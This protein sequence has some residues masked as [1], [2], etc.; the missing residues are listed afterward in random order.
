MGPSTGHQVPLPAE[1]TGRASPIGYAPSRSTPLRST[2]SQALT[3][4]Q[5]MIKALL[6]HLGHK[7]TVLAAS[8]A[9]S[10]AVTK[11][12]AQPVRG[13]P[14]MA[15]S[16][17]F[18]ASGSQGQQSKGSASQQGIR[19]SSRGNLTRNTTGSG[20]DPQ[21]D[22]HGDQIGV[23]SNAPH[24]E[25]STR[26]HSLLFSFMSSPPSTTALML[27]IFTW[28]MQDHLVVA[29][30][31][32]GS[33]DIDVLSDMNEHLTE[34]FGRGSAFRQDNGG[35]LKPG[36]PSMVLNKSIREYFGTFNRPVDLSNWT[37]YRDIPSSQEI[38]DSGR[39]H[40]HEDVEVSENIVVGPYESRDDYLERHYTLL[41]EDAVAPLRNAVSEVQSNPHLVEVDS[42]D[43]ACIYEKVPTRL[44]TAVNLTSAAYCQ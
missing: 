44:R 31:Y 27:P 41:R 1:Q 40:H 18:D 43:G 30:S 35:S 14:I 42:R 29:R 34:R 32:E 21:P 10:T 20:S 37:G 3:S 38:F 11:G 24:E 17:K 2:Y 22:D 25:Q 4:S 36:R 33:T 7:L 5:G 8:F 19:G 16:N 26:L 28:I 9:P 39:Q 6:H 12:K 23:I 15:A 13:S